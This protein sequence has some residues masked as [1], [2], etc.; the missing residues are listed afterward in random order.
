MTK[1]KVLFLAHFPHKLLT[2]F[3]VFL[4]LGEE[5]KSYISKS[6]FP[7]KKQIL[8]KKVGDTHIGLYDG[9]VEAI[10]V[11]I[12]MTRSFIHVIEGRAK[13]KTGR[14]RIKRVGDRLDF[15]YG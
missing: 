1:R 11:Y 14:R 12:M 9:W 4:G 15:F 6:K 5:R 8:E 3:F 10:V 2:L 7:R 13:G